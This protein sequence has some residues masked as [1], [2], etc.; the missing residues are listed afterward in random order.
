[1]TRPVIRMISRRP[2][3]RL[4]DIVTSRILQILQEGG[5]RFR[6][7]P[8]KIICTNRILYQNNL[9]QNKI[10]TRAKLVYII[11]LLLHS[12]FCLVSSQIL[13]YLSLSLTIA[14]DAYKNYVIGYRNN[15]INI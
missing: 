14:K 10:S 7:K 8:L 13:Q 9:L 3:D 1:M 12:F 11:S 15:S 6:R 2:R 4:G 5:Y